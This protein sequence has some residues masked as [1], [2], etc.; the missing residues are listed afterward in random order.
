MVGADIK[1]F[2]HRDWEPALSLIA[3]LEFHPTLPDRPGDQYWSLMAVWYQGS[4]PYG[5]FFTDVGNY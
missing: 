4:N 1:A 2:Q 5:P 3:G